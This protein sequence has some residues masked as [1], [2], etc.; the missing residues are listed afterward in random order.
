M[1]QSGRPA[2][3]TPGISLRFDTGL[4]Q[5]SHTYFCHQL[6]WG[7]SIEFHQS[8]ERFA[9]A[10]HRHITQPRGTSR[11]LTAWIN[12][13]RGRYFIP[14]T[15]RQK[16][17]GTPRARAPCQSHTRRSPRGSSQSSGC[18]RSVC[19]C[20]TLSP[21]HTQAPCQ[22]PIGGGGVD[23]CVR[24]PAMRVERDEV[25]R[26]DPRQQVSHVAPGGLPLTTWFGSPEAYPA[27]PHPLKA[28]RL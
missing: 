25:R 5:A 15:V 17:S 19:R 24:E 10:G 28:L 7:G 23:D 26:D 14:S 13:N 6:P 9:A 8:H 21:R 1:Y 20:R 22:L 18:P 2:P 3:E 4:R 27:V 11:M 12:R 16:P